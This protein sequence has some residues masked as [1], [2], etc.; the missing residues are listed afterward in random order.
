MNPIV[1]NEARLFAERA[2]ASGQRGACA[3]A[4]ELAALNTAMGGRMPDWYMGLLR[5]V[6]LCGLELKWL[7]EGVDGAIEWCGVKGIRSESLDC[8]PGV[9]ILERGYINVGSDPYGSGDSY[10]MPTDQ[11][12]DPPVFQVYHDVSDQA[13]EILADG[14]LQV[15]ARLSDLFR[16]AGLAND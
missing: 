3:D 16:H 5:S 10:F 6:P 8:L 14:L 1:E 15:A 7:A 13:D 9:A 11:G 2:M 4:A 12:D